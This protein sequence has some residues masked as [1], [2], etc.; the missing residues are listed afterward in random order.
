M[1]KFAADAILGTKAAVGINENQEIETFHR[2]NYTI[3]ELEAMHFVG[4]EQPL[5]KR[6]G[7]IIIR[8]GTVV[9]KY[10]AQSK[11]WEFMFIPR[12]CP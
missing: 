11:S 9:R 7:V 5:I 6:S 2:E 8:D 10:N 12:Y 1:F 3:E 4:K